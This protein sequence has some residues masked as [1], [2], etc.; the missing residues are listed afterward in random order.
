MH[1]CISNFVQ[2]ASSILTSS[3]TKTKHNWSNSLYNNRWWMCF[4]W[5]FL[6][7][8]LRQ[9][10]FILMSLQFLDVEQWIKENHTENPVEKLTFLFRMRTSSICIE[11]SGACINSSS[12]MRERVHS[13]GWKI[14]FY[15]N[16]FS[17]NKLILYKV[18]APR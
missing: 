6:L 11:L 7:A 16:I 17:K 4:L 12:E 10:T 9:S 18:N 5:A 14:H 3:V 1:C 2:F 8:Q 15:I 13:F